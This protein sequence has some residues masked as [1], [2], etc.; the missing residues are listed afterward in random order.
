MIRRVAVVIVCTLPAVGAMATYADPAAEAWLCNELFQPLTTEESRKPFSLDA[1]DIRVC[2]QPDKA[3]KNENIGVGMIDRFAFSKGDR[4]KD[5]VQVVIDDRRPVDQAATIIYCLPGQDICTFST[6]LMDQFFF[7]PLDENGHSLE[8]IN[9]VIQGIGSVSMAYFRGT[10]GSSGRTS[11]ESSEGNLD[12]GRHLRASFK[13]V[14]EPTRRMQEAEAVWAGVA[15][16]KVLNIPIAEKGSNGGSDDGKGNNRGKDKNNGS[17]GDGSQGPV[18]DFYDQLPFWGQCLVWT[19][20][21]VAAL[22]GVCCMCFLCY[23]G[24]NALVPTRKKMQPKQGE[25]AREY[26]HYNRDREFRNDEDRDSSHEYEGKESYELSNDGTEGSAASFADD[27]TRNS[28]HVPRLEDSKDRP[29]DD[30]EEDEYCAP[31]SAPRQTQPIQ[32][33]RPRTH[34]QSPEREESLD[35]HLGKHFPN[36]SSHGYPPRQHRNDGEG[37]ITSSRSAPPRKHFPNSSSHGYPPSQRHRDEEGSITSSRSAPPQKHFPNA[38]SHGYRPSQRT[39]NGPGSIT[40]SR[41]SPPKKHFPNASSHGYPPSQRRNDG[42]GSI[43]SSRSAPPKKH[44]PNA[45]SHG[46]PGQR[47]NAPKKHFPNSSVHGNRAPPPRSKSMQEPVNRAPPPRTKSMQGPGNRGPPP[48]TKSMQGPGS[49][50]PPPRTQSMQQPLKRMPPPRTKSMDESGYRAPP[51]R[52]NSAQQPRKKAPPPRTKSAQEPDHGDRL[53]QNSA[54]S[55]TSS[56]SADL[57]DD[58]S[59]DTRDDS[60]GD[61]NNTDPGT[62]LSPDRADSRTQPA[63]SRINSLSPKRTSNEDQFPYAPSHDNDR[64]ND[65]NGGKESIA[66]SQ[67]MPASGL[68]S[69][70]SVS[71]T[72]AVQR[73]PNE[74]SPR[75]AS[76]AARAAARAAANESDSDSDSDDEESVTASRPKPAIVLGPGRR[77][78]RLRPSLP[79]SG[80]T[81]SGDLQN[82]PGDKAPS[83]PT[84]SMDETGRADGPSRHNSALTSAS[85]HSTD[86]DDHAS[87]DTTDDCLGT[88]NSRGTGTVRRMKKKDQEDAR[89]VASEASASMDNTSHSVSSTGTRKKRRMKKKVVSSLNPDL[90]L[91][92]GS[93]GTECRDYDDTRSM[94]SQANASMD[95][96]GHSVSSTGKKRRMKKKANG[97]LGPDNVIPER[98]AD[99]ASASMDTTGHSVSSTGTRKKLRPKKKVVGSSFNLPLHSFGQKFGGDQDDTFVPLKN[100]PTD[101]NPKAYIRSE[102]SSIEDDDAS[103]AG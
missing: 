53:S 1:P 30:E 81:G 34:S 44:F 76:K 74:L 2:I 31:L 16:I 51:P 61:T 64:Q 12:G 35:D 23:L 89:S 78:S 88:T 45:S 94:A 82:K 102:M 97:S 29:A 77:I 52:T 32:R 33:E 72:P 3:T 46:Y 92:E 95:S 85:D 80:N 70:P 100:K 49:R 83:P 60:I 22:L 28:H 67:S 99:E 66:T 24:H 86:F 40:S 79:S 5:G 54:H 65:N 8:P 48:R 56:S 71:R 75:Q 21:A 4:G 73:K 58:T 37:S 38:S 19:G 10:G 11:A 62:V 43:T 47:N 15:D 50:G 55:S 14:M 59:R 41:S 68:G 101:A 17:G 87:L 6:K 26:G 91:P 103:F 93:A 57:D 13:F 27:G 36:A 25:N 18:A 42:E 7:P 84:K 98:P 63:G 20:V 90:V 39:S 96:T 69:G 9:S